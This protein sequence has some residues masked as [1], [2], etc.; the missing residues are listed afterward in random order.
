MSYYLRFSTEIAVYIGYYG[1]ADRSESVPMTLSD[2]EKWEREGSIIFWR[3]SL[4]M[5]V[6]YWPRTT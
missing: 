4:H 5:L 2:L 1:S 6:R 3:I